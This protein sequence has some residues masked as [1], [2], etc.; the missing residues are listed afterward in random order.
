MGKLIDAR[1]CF[2]RDPEKLA[3]EAEARRQFLQKYGR[4]FLSV[5]RVYNLR[6]ER[7]KRSARR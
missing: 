1:E 5:A 6:E 7:E 4:R 3:R 2:P